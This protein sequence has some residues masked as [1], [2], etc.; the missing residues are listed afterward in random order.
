MNNLCTLILCKIV[1]DHA[2]EISQLT[3]VA[4]EKNEN[5]MAASTALA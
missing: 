2:E 1:R 4:M 5:A 3:N